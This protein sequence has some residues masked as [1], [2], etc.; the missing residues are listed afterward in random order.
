MS[1]GKPARLQAGVLIASIIL[2]SPKSDTLIVQS[3]GS[4]DAISRFS[5]LM[6]R[7]MTWDSGMEHRRIVKKTTHDGPSSAHGTG[8]ACR[9]PFLSACSEAR[10]GAAA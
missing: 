2:T 3:L 6:S 5:G 9:P 10:R 4:A 7:W 8:G 1:T